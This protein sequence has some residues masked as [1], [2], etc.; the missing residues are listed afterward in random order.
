LTDSSAAKQNAI[1]PAVTYLYLSPFRVINLFPI[2]VRL[3]SEHGVTVHDV[4]KALSDYYTQGLGRRQLDRRLKD[5]Y[6]LAQST[7]DNLILGAYWES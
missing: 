7:E 3:R 2:W 5:V 4:I 1:D 6:A